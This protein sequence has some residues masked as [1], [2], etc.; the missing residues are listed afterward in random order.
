[1]IIFSLEQWQINTIWT[2][3]SLV[4]I[5]VFLHLALW[6]ANRFERRR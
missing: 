1:M 2:L 6:F 5:V 3:S 4:L